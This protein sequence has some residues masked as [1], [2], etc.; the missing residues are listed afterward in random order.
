MKYYHGK[1][2]K[3][4]KRKRHIIIGLVACFVVC[5]FVYIYCVVNPVVINAT[6]QTILSLSTS[7]VNDA[8][9]EVLAKNNLTYDDLVLVEY[10]VN[11]DV[12]MISLNTVELNKL[13]REIYQVSQQKL[14][15]M[16]NKGVEVSLGTFTGFPI[17][18][19]YGPVINLKLVPVGAVSANFS[20]SFKSA[21]INQTNHSLYVKLFA[22]VSLILP[23][24]SSTI[25]CTT[26]VL[27]AES[28]IVGDVPDV[29]LGSNNS[30]NF[31]PQ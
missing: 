25:D 13:T 11:G 19:G 24:Y 9:F 28:V 10:D 23:A 22:S 4:K 20:S 3:I 17:L 12:I 21:G 18:S 6:R 8:V 14:D 1:Y 27:V 2:K 31:S 29:Y 7:A 5:V 16:G 15:I 26:E 30:L